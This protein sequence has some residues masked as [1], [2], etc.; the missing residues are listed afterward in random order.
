[1]K[2]KLITL[3]SMILIVVVPIIAV[4]F[5]SKSKIS[6]DGAWSFVEVQTIKSDGSFTS[7]F[8]KEG[9]AIFSHSYY[10]F[11]WT[12]HVAAAHSWQMADSVKLNRF[13]QSIINTGTFELK[14]SVLTTKAA[15]AMN[16]MFTN[17]LATF[18]C[19]FNGDTL[20]LTGLNV[21]SSDNIPHPIYAGGSHIVTKLLKVRTK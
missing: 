17:G 6:I 4:S 7:T 14:D 20:V 19:S 3:S 12:S 1:M 21:F 18:K 11:C 2:T 8:P 13:N 10:S 5:T 15:F 16:P 9:I